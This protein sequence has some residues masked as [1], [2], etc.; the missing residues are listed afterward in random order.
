M[1]I[2]VVMVDGGFREKFHLLGFLEDQSFPR[3]DY[4]IIWVEFYGEVKNELRD[5]HGV[6][7]I[8][9]GNKK[10]TE[11]H[12]SRCFNEGIRRS[13]GEIIVIPD[14]DVAVEPDFLQAVYDEHRSCEKLVLYFRRW[15]EPQEAHDDARS[16]SLEH[17]RSVASLGNPMNY[18]G[19]LTVRKK[20]LL[21]INGYDEDMTFSSGF[22]A[23]GWDVYTRL[24]NLGLHVMWHPTKKLYHPWHPST[25][26]SSERYRPQHSITYKRQRNL[27]ALANY[28]LDPARNKT[29]KEAPDRARESAKKVI[30][31][32]IRK[33]IA[34]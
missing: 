8:T 6:Q 9:L 5:R 25:L 20:W 11:Y 33:F 32:K 7:V 17:L 23:N 31:G 21:E 26:V 29:V 27:T 22:H 28:G 12:S 19:C 10:D 15:D 16:Y 1:K 3:E 24:N 18:G 34:D 30:L 4:E 2:S 13:R 14:A